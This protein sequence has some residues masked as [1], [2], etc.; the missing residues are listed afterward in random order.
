[1]KPMTLV[2]AAHRLAPS[3]GMGELGRWQLPAYLSALE[4]PWLRDIVIDANGDDDLDEGNYKSR[5]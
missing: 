1:M 4:R 3:W 2:A 5:G